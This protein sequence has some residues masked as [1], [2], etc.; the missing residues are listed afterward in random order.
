M[1]LI[2]IVSIIPEINN[3]RIER[4]EIVASEILIRLE[5]DFIVASSFLFDDDGGGSKA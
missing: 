5:G 3:N 2:W 4:I 1:E